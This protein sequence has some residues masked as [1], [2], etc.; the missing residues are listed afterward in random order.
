MRGSEFTFKVSPSGS[1]GSRDVLG[2]RSPNSRTVSAPSGRSLQLKPRL[3]RLSVRNFLVT[4]A[5]RRG[6][7]LLNDAVSFGARGS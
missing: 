1:A 3:G 2:T 7:R 5:S 4:G 6:N